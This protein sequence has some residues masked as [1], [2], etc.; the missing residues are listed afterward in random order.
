MN[1]D[2]VNSPAATAVYANIP[3][4]TMLT[5]NIYDP[6]VAPGTI[7]QVPVTGP[8]ITGG[9]GPQQQ[10][11]SLPTE[12]TTMNNGTVIMQPQQHDVATYYV[13]DDLA[14]GTNPVVVDGGK[15]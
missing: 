13:S 8:Q 15:Y 12:F 5:T 6:A 11:E 2:T 14:A 7:P 4:T 1:G 3:E 9:V 10:P